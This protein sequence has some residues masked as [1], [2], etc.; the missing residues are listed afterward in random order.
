M[1][2]EKFE[3]I[4]SSFN[5]RKTLAKLRKNYKKR[6]LNV[7]FLVT[8]NQKWAY[9][10][11]YEEFEK[12]KNYS[13]KVIIVP[14][15][16]LYNHKEIQK[17]IEENYNFFRERKIKVEICYD[18]TKNK[19]KNLKHHSPDIVFFEQPFVLPNKLKPYSVSKYA[20]PLFCPYSVSPTPKILARGARFYNALFKFFTPNKQLENEYIKTN[21]FKKG[22]FLYTGHPKLENINITNKPLENKTIIYAPHFSLLNTDLKLSTFNWSGNFILDFAKS[23]R[24]FIWVFKPH[25]N[26]KKHFIESG[27]KSKKEMDEYFIEWKN[28]GTIYDKGDY[29]E[30]FHNSNALITDC[31]SF[32]IEYF[33]YNKPVFHLVSNNA[34]NKNSFTEAIS[35]TYYKIFSKEALESYLHEVLI[36]KNDFLKPLRKKYIQKFFNKKNQSSKRIIGFLDRILKK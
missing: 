11:L 15:K 36:K 13:P 35:S 28:V 6:A 8:K 34:T 23:H 12:N 33:L 14:K 24:E 27:Y 7:I 29:F 18:I 4:L 17:S 1:L 5:H 3:I 26:F 19:Y 20:L 16:N 2:K 22:L 32:L 25:P 31:S 30:L 10:T 21:E 9:Q